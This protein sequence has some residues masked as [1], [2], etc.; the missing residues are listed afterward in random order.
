MVR[1]QLSYTELL[2]AIRLEEVKEVRFFTTDE[3]ATH[4]EGPCLV[5]MNDG[6]V[7]QSFVR[8]GDY[9]CVPRQR[10]TPDAVYRHLCTVGPQVQPHATAAA[11]LRRHACHARLAMLTPSLWSSC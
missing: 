9:R 2:K 5:V 6:S 4:L 8:D 3:D 7:A 1:K 10:S 11:K